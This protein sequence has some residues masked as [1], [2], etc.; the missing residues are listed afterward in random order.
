[1]TKLD[2]II[3]LWQVIK[4]TLDLGTIVYLVWRLRNGVN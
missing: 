1:M 2:L 4:V 3:I